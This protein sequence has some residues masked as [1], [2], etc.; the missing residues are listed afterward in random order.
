MPYYLCANGSIITSGEG[1]LDVR[2]GADDD[3]QPEKHPCKDFFDTCCSLELLETEEKKI[4]P[5]TKYDKCGFRNYNGVGFGITQRDNEAQ[6]GKQIMIN[7]DC[8]QFSILFMFFLLS[9]AEFPWAIALLMKHEMV[10][11]TL[12]VYTCGGSLIHPSV[13]LTAAHCVHNKKPEQFIARAGEWDTQT[14]SEPFPF[15]DRTVKDVKIHERYRPGSLFN[16]IA[17]LFLDAP[18]DLVENVNTACLPPPDV[19]LDTE[20][21]F[22]TG[23][24]KD[25]FGKEGAYQAILKRV[26]LPI[27]NRDDCQAR[28]RDT[29]LGRFFILD[30]SFICAGGERGKDTCT[31]SKFYHFFIYFNLDNF[32]NFDNFDFQGDGGSP[33]SCPIHGTNNQ[34]YQTGIVAW[35]VGCGDANPGVYVN[36]PLFRKWIDD[37]FEH[38]QLDTKSYIP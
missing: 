36:I 3:P 33:L 5:I 31:V 20:R 18:M 21:C 6:F 11:V 14:K 13:V 4:N 37:E 8:E 38:R 24:G 22:A 9:I 23:W 27:I 32:D 30:P 1:I 35:G 12:S 25:K 16:D 34:Y 2:I 17:L 29:R 10:D 28:L 19:K 7:I 26:E 15:Q